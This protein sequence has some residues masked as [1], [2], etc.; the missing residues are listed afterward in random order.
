M[1]ASSTLDA[2]QPAGAHSAAA[3]PGLSNVTNHNGFQAVSPK[4]MPPSKDIIKA[5]RKAMKKRVEQRTPDVDIETF[6][7]EKN[8]ELYQD[9]TQELI[10]L[11][12]DNMDP[13]ICFF[14]WKRISNEN[15]NEHWLNNET[16]YIY[17]P[18]LS[19]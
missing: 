19:L 11:G 12:F 4:P 8:I 2:T 3:Q 14:R 17:V 9:V 6:T 18:E 10:S 15:E 16:H 13:R 7:D 1:Q 5:L